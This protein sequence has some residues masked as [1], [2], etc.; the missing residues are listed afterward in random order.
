MI[1]VSQVYSDAIKLV[2]SKGLGRF[3]NK[4]TLEVVDKEP[5]MFRKTKAPF[6]RTN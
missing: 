4:W 2:Q 1:I 3:P 6:I 5:F